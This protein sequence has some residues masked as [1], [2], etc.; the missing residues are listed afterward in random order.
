MKGNN[1]AAGL[2]REAG[3]RGYVFMQSRSCIT[4]IIIIIII[5]I[6]AT[7]FQC[8]AHSPRVNFVPFD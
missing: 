1:Q 8:R 2:N 6:I 5:I 3:M 4:I 7:R